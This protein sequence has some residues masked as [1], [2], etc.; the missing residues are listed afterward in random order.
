V[1]AERLHTAAKALVAET[2]GTAGHLQELRSAVRQAA[3]NPGDG[4]SQQQ[5]APL[6]DALF[7]WLDRAP[8]EEMTA[9][10]REALKEL[11][12]EPLL[13]NQL[14][15]RVET[16]F[17]RNGVTPSMAADELDELVA[18]LEELRGSLG[19]L[20]QAFAY[21]SI[22]ADTLEAGEVEVSVLVPRG[23]V[24]EGLA[25]LGQEFISI[26]KII[27][28]FSELLTG[29]RDDVTVR[30]IASSEFEIFVALAPVVAAHF[31]KAVETVLNIYEKVH[32]IRKASEELE[33][34]GVEPSVVALLQEQAKTITR[35]EINVFVENLL[36]EIQM[37]DEAR[38]NELRIDLAKQLVELATRLDHGYKVDLNAAALPL[39]AAGE[40]EPSG[41]PAQRAAVEE[42]IS[43][44]GRLKAFK[45]TGKPILALPE[46]AS[47]EGQASEGEVS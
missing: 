10:E 26:K 13:G 5:V 18:A 11:N 43:A 16:V 9:L 32:S 35:N 34:T 29:S 39:P 44:R 37:D 14:R 3:N 6:R 21:F 36:G 15:K 7:K 20:I 47:S 2:D 28:P 42:V 8:S 33:K 38:R 40:S 17:R 24:H 22:G 12:V 45:L 23:A 41:R 31:A 25:A 30:T 1:N 4:A 19:Y 46:S 27:D